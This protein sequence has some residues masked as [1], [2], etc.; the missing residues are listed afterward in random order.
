VVSKKK[1]P[2]VNAE[3]AFTIDMPADDQPL[4]KLPDDLAKKQDFIS[5]RSVVD[6]LTDTIVIGR[7]YRKFREFFA[8]YGDLVEELRNRLPKS[9]S[10]CKIG[11]K[12]PSGIVTPYS[13]SDFCEEFFGVCSERVRQEL[14]WRK[15]WQDDLGVDVEM[16]E[17]TDAPV[18]TPKAKIDP[19]SDEGQDLQQEV[20]EA[21]TETAVTK[22]A[23]AVTQVQLLQTKTVAQ[24]WEWA[25]RRMANQMDSLLAEVEKY[26]DKAFPLVTYVRKVQPE[27][28][29]IHEDAKKIG[30][31]IQPTTPAPPVTGGD[32]LVTSDNE[33]REIVD[34]KLEAAGK[35]LATKAGE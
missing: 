29:A 18:N 22:L 31:D 2:D 11:V 20:E 6:L 34:A 15:R 9:G 21:K 1:T 27:I 5:K 28:C 30:K 4:P 10:K 17:T 7:R 35:L 32:S 16:E 8:V 3:C 23:A 25:Y 12:M 26:G 24:Q 19:K 33:W 13:W 14:V